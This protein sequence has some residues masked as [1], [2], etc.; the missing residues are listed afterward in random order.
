MLACTK[1][2][3][4]DHAAKTQDALAVQNAEAAEI[5]DHTAETPDTSVDAVENEEAA[6]INYNSTISTC[7]KD[8]QSKFN[9]F[10]DYGALEDDDEFVEVAD[11]DDKVNEEES[12][13]IMNYNS[14]ISAYE[15]TSSGR[16]LI[17]LP[18]GTAMWLRAPP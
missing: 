5:D 16:E 6:E 11:D 18:K 3:Y 2:E 8:Q 4:P 9:S 1:N 14:A 17:A 10:F 13:R 12:L 15:K 7:E